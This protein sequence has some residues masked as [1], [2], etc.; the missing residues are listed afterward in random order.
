MGK[1]IQP[2]DMRLSIVKPVSAKWMVDLYD[3]LLAHPQIITN[4]FKHVGITD[5]LA[6]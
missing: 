3:Y 6:K 2:V 1:E 5:F 4:G